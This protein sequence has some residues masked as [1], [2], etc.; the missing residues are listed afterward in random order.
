MEWVANAEESMLA[1]ES[2]LEAGSQEK[3]RK[4]KGESRPGTDLLET[5]NLGKQN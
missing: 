1:A 5:E 4:S 3:L 2:I